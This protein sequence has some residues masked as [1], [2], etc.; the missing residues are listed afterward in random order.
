MNEQVLLNGFQV[1]V[2]VVELDDGLRIRLSL[3]DW[4]RCQLHRGQRIPLQRQGRPEASLFL[5]EA[6]EMPPVA[7]FVLENGM[8]MAG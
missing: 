2:F 7:W 8:R 1:W 5:A 4:E 3:D 6:V